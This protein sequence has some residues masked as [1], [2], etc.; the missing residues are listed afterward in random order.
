MATIV[1][2]AALWQTIVAASV[3]GIGVTFVY[4]LAILGASRASEANR[5]G[6]SGEAAFFGI[7]AAIGV[8]ATGAAVVAGV[9]VMS[10]K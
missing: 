9:I 4:S 7:L 2:T 8:L 6:R 10:T 5:R 1:D 3:A